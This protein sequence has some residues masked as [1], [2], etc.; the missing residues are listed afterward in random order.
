MMKKILI[1]MVLALSL[2]GA[3]VFAE[4]NKNKPAPKP[5][6]VA[7]THSGT[8]KGGKRKYHRRHH[9]RIKTRAAKKR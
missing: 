4:Q 8:M 9:R 2:A 5:G 6:A 7:T 3:S 1:G